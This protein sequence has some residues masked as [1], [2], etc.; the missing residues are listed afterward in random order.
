[1]NLVTLHSSLTNKGAHTRTEASTSATHWSTYDS[2][3]YHADHHTLH[4]ANFGSGEAILIDFYF[5]TFG[6]S[7]P[8][9]WGQR[10]DFDQT[11]GVLCVSP[12]RN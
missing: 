5:G 11:T 3:N 6:S 1:M 9:F 10:Y 7:A 8:V 12:A 4:K 2:D